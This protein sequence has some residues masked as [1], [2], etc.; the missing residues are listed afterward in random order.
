MNAL[1][2]RSPVEFDSRET[3]ASERERGSGCGK[4]ERKPR[5]E[6]WARECASALMNVARERSFNFTICICR[7]SPL[8]LWVQ[9]LHMNYIVIP[10]LPLTCPI[11]CHFQSVKW[12]TYLESLETVITVTSTNNSLFNCNNPQTVSDLELGTGKTSGI[13][14]CTLTFWASFDADFLAI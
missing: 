1:A 11:K 5:K 2:L 3:C 6:T 13:G 9:S 8:L 4:R 14:N 12:V 10:F 7:A